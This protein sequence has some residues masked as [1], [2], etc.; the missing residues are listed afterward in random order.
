ME[1]T[2]VELDGDRVAKIWQRRS[3]AELE[4]LTTFYDAV[5]A[6]GLGLQTPRILEV[7]DLDG[8]VASVE[9]RLTGRPLWVADGSSPDLTDGQV[10]AVTDVLAALAAVRPTPAM[11]VLPVLEDEAAFDTTGTPFS[12]DLAALVERR[13]ERF[14]EPLQA[15]LPDVDR[16]TTVVV[17][18]LRALDPEASSLVHGD[19][20]P[21]N[22]L[23]DGHGRPCAVVDFGFLSTVGD[24]AFDA[25][26]AASTYDMYG[27][28]A[29]ETEAVLDRAVRDRLGHAPERL[30]AHRAAYALVTSCCFSVSGSD[31][32]FAWCV[33]ML[34]RPDV[35]TAL[36]L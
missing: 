2:V 4:T 20:I 10:A 15:Q 3:R 17:D 36:G 1:G 5:A 6:A 27:P 12:H 25:A 29:A 33:R 22:I 26:V 7:L 13:V 18:R 21:A 8:T 14:R 28:R 24:P 34:G 23:V 30:A 9:V 16:V 19:L 31:G 11:G 32:H 35:R